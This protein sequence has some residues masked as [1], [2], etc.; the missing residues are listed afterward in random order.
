MDFSKVKKV[1]IP[2][3]NVKR[4]SKD[5]IVLWKA[6]EWHTLFEG[7]ITIGLNQGNTSITGDVSDSNYEDVEIRRGITSDTF[8][9]A[10]IG[11]VYSNLNTNVDELKFRIT[12]IISTNPWKEI[13]ISTSNSSVSEYDIASYQTIESEYVDISNNNQMFYPFYAVKDYSFNSPDASTDTKV[14][15]YLYN[16][17]SDNT[18]LR[19]GVARYKAKSIFDFNVNKLLQI[20]KI[21]QFY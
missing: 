15:L 9:Q 10:K 19:I 21:E 2:E 18:Q 17:N 16:Y 6:K 7:T 3:G 12:A 5:N 13:V 4:I 20:K 14:F 8:K 1:V 11:T